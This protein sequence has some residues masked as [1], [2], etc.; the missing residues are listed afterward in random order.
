MA[1]SSTLLKQFDG[2]NYSQYFPQ[3]LPLDIA[4]QFVNSEGKNSNDIFN[5][6][7]KYCQYW[8]RKTSQTTLNLYQEGKE[9]FSSDF[10]VC[11]SERTIKWSKSITINNSRTISLT[12]PSSLRV[13]AS[14]IGAQNLAAKA[15]CYITNLEEGP[16]KVCYLEQGTSGGTSSSKYNIWSDDNEVYLCKNDQF[17]KE[18]FAAKIT[19]PEGTISYEQ[20]TI[21]NAYP[22]SSIEN[23]YLYSFLGIPL[24]EIAQKMDFN[25]QAGQYVGTGTFGPKNSNVLSFSKAPQVLMF[26]NDRDSDSYN[27]GFCFPKFQT[28]LAIIYKALQTNQS[29]MAVT[30]NTIYK[31]NNKT[32]MW[33][34][35]SSNDNKKN[36][37]FQGNLKNSVY[38]YFALF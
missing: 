16:T 21:R 4:N 38:S 9:I 22:D 3:N 37:Y 11:S 23:N 14:Y 1:D 33:Y 5:Y 34:F 12:S 30:L 8:W 27:F 15:P 25:I 17:C 6:L 31:N 35:E 28:N 7:R 36:A 20:S 29:L 26:Q 10:L 24:E 2:S 32:I 13:E 19:V 18:V